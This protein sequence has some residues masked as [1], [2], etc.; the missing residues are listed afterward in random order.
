MSVVAFFMGFMLSP[1]GVMVF[2]CALAT[3]L[4]WGVAT[5]RFLGWVTDEI[6]PGAES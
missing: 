3:V 5:G 2:T 6:E 4:L 1:V